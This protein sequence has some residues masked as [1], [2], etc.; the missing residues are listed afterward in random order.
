MA[1]STSWRSTSGSAATAFSA[2]WPIVAGQTLPDASRSQPSEIPNSTPKI[3][4]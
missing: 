2:A 1:G 4:N 3:V